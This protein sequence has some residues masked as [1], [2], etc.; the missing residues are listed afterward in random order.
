[1]STYTC[2]NYNIFKKFKNKFKPF[3]MLLCCQ[4][5]PVFKNLAKTSETPKFAFLETPAW[6]EADIGA[7]NAIETAITSLSSACQ[8]E[9]LPDPFN[10]IIDYHAAVFAAENSHYYGPFLDNHSELLSEKLRDRL[11]VSKTTLASEYIAALNARDKI[12][13]SLETLLDD[14]DAV[15]CLAA[16]GAAP[17]GFETTGSAIFNGL[18]TYLGVPC[19]SL[20]LLTTENMQLGLQLV[21]KRGNERKLFKTANWIENHLK[22]S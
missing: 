22:A 8:R 12:Y 18:W 5:A 13:H 4:L 11:I 6:P 21:G 7:K 19:L 10:K 20:P 17:I 2:S 14:Y 3:E 9:R 1:M 16:T 15:L